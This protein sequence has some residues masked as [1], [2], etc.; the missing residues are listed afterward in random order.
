M[1]PPLRDELGVH[2]GPVSAE[3]APSWTLHDPVRNAF[4]RIGWVGFEILARW[5]EGRP[6]SI[7][8]R[9]NDETS[10][11]ID[12][13]DV[14]DVFTFLSQNQLLRAASP[15]DTQRLVAVAAAARRSWASWL[16]H[17]YLFIRIPLLRPDRFLDATRGVAAALFSRFFLCLTG[18][19]LLMGVSLI[20]SQWG[21][22][23]ATLVDTLTPAGFVQYALVLTMVKT[24]HEFA[25]AA[26]AKRFGCRVPTMGIAFLVLWPVLY[27]DVNDSWRL[28][29]RGQRL[30][31]GAAGI[32]AE[33]AIAAWASL[34]W[35]L[36]PDGGAREMAFML[37]AITW[38]SSLVINLSPFM[39][40]DGYFLL[41]D[42]V[43]IPNLH[44][45]AFAMAR[46]WMRE[47]LFGLAEPAPEPFGAA[48]RR[49]LILFAVVVWIYRLAVFL[50]IAVLVYHFFIKAVGLMLFA[51][52]ISWF[53][54]L[55]IM[56]EVRIWWRSRA[57]ILAGGRIRWSGGAAAI[58]LLAM[59]VPWRGEV[60]A[61]AIL[62]AS[63]SVALFLPAGG[64][65]IRQVVADGQ[66]VRAG[67]T[68]FIA[69]SFDVRGRRRLAEARV[70][71]LD[72]E[73]RAVSFDGAF[74]E[75]SSVLRDA[76]GASLAELASLRG[77]EERLTIRAALA[78]TLVDVL[79]GL[80]PGDSLSPHERLATLRGDGPPIIDAYIGEIDLGRVSLGDRAVF[81]PD[82]FSRRQ[83]MCRVVAVDRVT[84]GILP[85]K[86]LA[87]SH[88][89]E[90]A[91]RDKDGTPIPER[92]LYH[93]RLAPETDFVP[94]VQMRGVVRI[95]GRKQ[96]LLG[97]AVLSAA[98][99]ILR[100]WGT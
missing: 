26:T 83:V 18:L 36:L 98:S 55:P 5:Q 28:T 67:D 34:A 15:A 87:R 8:R 11:A 61:P 62:K 90:I 30:A 84:T 75:E 41:M 72:Y 85:D 3:G 38:V 31:I 13:D 20:W 53:V 65:L 56:R 66:H 52:E 81:T 57:A 100:E 89:G 37:S 80:H 60:S 86:E 32:L 97:R 4:F 91:V 50:G 2:A 54:A 68:L 43:D 71:T 17:N 39:R 96:S 12:E 76:M 48:K 25:H 44:Q 23:R 45:R 77:E 64:E 16:L 24:I 40:F 51:V 79:P 74:R 94:T 1:L 70:R 69:G 19:A 95:N 14:I 7:C 73:I 10:L 42:A 59:I 21:I 33:M 82:I 29:R 88:G 46:W 22:Y 78:G 27:T 6:D 9:V 35:G 99:V 63:E 58:L 92:A 93:V 47:M 49:F